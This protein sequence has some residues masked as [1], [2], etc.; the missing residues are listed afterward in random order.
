MNTYLVG[1]AVRDALLE[2]PVK[3]RD[4]V[5]VGSTPEAMLAAGF[6]AVG[7]DFPVFLHPETKE[8]YALARTER[9]TGKGYHGFD[10]VA[11]PS[12]TLEQDLLRRD[13]TINAIAQTPEG[14]RIDPYQGQMD[15]KNRCLR[16][17]SPAFVEDPVRL[18]RVARFYATLATFP[19]TVHADT[20]ELMR[21]MVVNG[22]V[23]HL[24]PERVWQELWKSLHTEKPVYFFEL[25]QTVNAY[26]VLFP[27]ASLD[28][29]EFSRFSD[30]TTDATLR[31]AVWI[32]QKDLSVQEALTKRLKVP[33]EIAQLAKLIHRQKILIDT[34]SDAPD[35]TW[36]NFL[37]RSDA[38]RRVALFEKSCD[39]WCFVKGTAWSQR[40]RQA[41]LRVQAVRVPPALTNSS[42]RAIQ[43]YLLET[44]MQALIEETPSPNATD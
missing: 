1:G 13:L 2:R 6:E 37:I 31:A 18:L 41:A 27:N 22:E 21:A 29:T 20:L 12:V 10:C 40:L 25:L 9:K 16:H 36:L 19:F 43:A 33:K 15:L 34:L 4:W 5:V 7:K 38:L 8:E 42:P 24:V 28:L 39:Y 30:F 44:R 17:V 23:N 11:D 14:D 26:D 32:V 3:E 35:A